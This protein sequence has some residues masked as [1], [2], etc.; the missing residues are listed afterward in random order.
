MLMYKD[1]K[2]VSQRDLINLLRNCHSYLYS[3]R[4]VLMKFTEIARNFHALDV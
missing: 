3:L 1:F 4:P 2:S